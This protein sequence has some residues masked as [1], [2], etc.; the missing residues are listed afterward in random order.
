[1][2]NDRQ[3]RHSKLHSSREVLPS[4]QLHCRKA[5]IRAAIFRL[6]SNYM[7]RRDTEDLPFLHRSMLAWVSS[8]LGFSSG[9]R[10]KE[11]VEEESLDVFKGFAERLC[12]ETW[13]F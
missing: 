11:N 2:G 3:T 6:V 1:M 10:S 12:K 7:H 8:F 4:D 5:F 9:L 13:G